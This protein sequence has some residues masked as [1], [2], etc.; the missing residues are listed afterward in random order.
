MHFRLRKNNLKFNNLKTDYLHLR[1][2]LKRQKKIR[3]SNRNL[4]NNKQQNMWTDWNK[5]KM[6]EIKWYYNLK[7][8]WNKR[9][10]Q[11]KS[12]YMI[13]LMNNFHILLFKIRKLLNSLKI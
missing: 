7:I 11:I 9:F 6:S 3:A 5:V 1:D 12:F 4:Y 10:K 8:S 13:D 2:S